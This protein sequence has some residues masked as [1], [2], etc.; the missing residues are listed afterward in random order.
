MHTSS[1]RASSWPESSSSAPQSPV[2]G[3]KKVSDAPFSPRRWPSYIQ[4]LFPMAE[5]D[6]IEAIFKGKFKAYYLLKLV[7]RY[8]NPMAA[9]NRLVTKTF[10]G[11]SLSWCTPGSWK[12]RSPES[13]RGWALPLGGSIT[14]FSFLGVLFS[15]GNKSSTWPSIS[16]AW[17]SPPHSI[18]QS[19]RSP[20]DLR[21][22]TSSQHSHRN[23]DEIMVSSKGVSCDINLTMTTPCQHHTF[24]NRYY[25]C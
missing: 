12:P 8:S 13:T 5:I 17:P 16:S 24:Q 1:W 2:P 7:K 18:L 14:R 22:S 15:P 9:S 10:A 6:Q 23:L 25:P 19:G 11:S 21:T 20:T 3:F 4:S